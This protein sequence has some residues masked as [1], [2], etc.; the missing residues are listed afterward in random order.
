[1]NSKDFYS[2]TQF[3]KAYE[4]SKKPKLNIPD[5]N[6]EIIKDQQMF[7]SFDTSVQP[8]PLS[9]TSCFIT[10]TTN[11]DPNII[12]SSM[13]SVPN[14]TSSFDSLNI[15]LG[16]VLT[17]FTGKANI[18][19]SESKELIKCSQCSSF[20]NNFTRVEANIFYCNLCKERNTLKDQIDT[21]ADIFRHPVLEFVSKNL[22]EP[23]LDEKLFVGSSFFAT[24]VFNSPVFIF[25]VDLS[26]E[27][28][29]EESVNAIVEVLSDSSFRFLYSKMALVTISGRIGLLRNNSLDVTTLD[30]VTEET[31]P[32]IPPDVFFDTENVSSVVKYLEK[33]SPA[34]KPTTPSNYLFLLDVLCCLSRYSVGSKVAFF[35]Q[36]SL[37]IQDSNIQKFIDSSCSLSLF[38]TKKTGLEKLATYTMGGVFVYSPD[39]LHKTKADLHNI[40]ATK[41]AFGVKIEVK[42]SNAIRKNAIYANTLLENLNHTELCQ[43]DSMSTISY[44]FFVD[45]HVS[46]KEHLYFQFVIEYFA[47]DASHRTLVINTRLRASDKPTDFYSAISFDTLFACLAK[48]ISSDAKEAATNSK[49][50]E[51]LLCRFLAYYRKTCC[52][53]ISTTQFVLPETAK[54]LPL[55]YQSLIKHKS[56]SSSLNEVELRRVTNLTV[57]QTLRYFYPR[58]FTITDYYMQQD[59]TK[60]KPLS[61]SQSVLDSSEIYV[62]ENSQKIFLYFGKDVDE[63]LREA[64]FNNNEE[65]AILM[66]MVNEICTNYGYELPIVVV[67]EGK[68]GS[69]VE[70]IGFMVEDTLNGVPSYHDYICELHFKV[71]KY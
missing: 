21:T 45:E 64:L 11:P 66:N 50:V 27:A 37:S 36:A 14:S 24:R 65:N 53:E 10:E 69:E 6:T 23:E 17:P 51:D 29:L 1:M 33:L 40:C 38:T 62:L 16:L 4:A 31:V 2:H 15:P 30:L 22:P 13:Y 5:L 9:T 12:R 49:H 57:E 39:Q 42:T 44:T 34:K 54:L 68:G 20:V 26:S 59:I 25:V 46:T 48:Y 52:K 32:F 60:I 58:L 70:F 55:L 67:E 28:L 35:T 47:H 71:Q 19:E 63:S 3:P 56:Y 7:Y 41:S 18:F 61:L 8:P 43:M